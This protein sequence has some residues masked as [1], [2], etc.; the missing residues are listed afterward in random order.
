MCIFFNV[1][2]ILWMLVALSKRELGI[3][4]TGSISIHSVIIFFSI[5][6]DICGKKV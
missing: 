4:R 6:S 2:F 5:A 1:F 3:V